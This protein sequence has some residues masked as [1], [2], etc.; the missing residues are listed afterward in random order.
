MNIKFSTFNFQHSHSQFLPQKDTNVKITLEDGK[1]FDGIFN[2]V[3]RYQVY[4]VLE[5]IDKFLS[6]AS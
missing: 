6:F 5:K 4:K 3:K 2:G 1:M